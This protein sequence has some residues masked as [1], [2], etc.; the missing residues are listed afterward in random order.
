MAG[1]GFA[2][3]RRRRPAG[4]TPGKSPINCQSRIPNRLAMRIAPRTLLCG[5]AWRIG[6]TV[7]DTGFDELRELTGAAGDKVSLAIGMMGWITALTFNDRITESAVLGDES[8][9]LIESIGD[10]ALTV[11]LIP[12]VLQAKIQAGQTAETHRLS[13]HLIDLAD[14]DA[15]MGNLILGSPLTLG[16][17]VPWRSPKC[18][19]DN[20][21]FADDFRCGP[22]GGA[23]SR[24]DLFATAVLS[25]GLQHHNRRDRARRRHDERRCR[26]AHTGR[27]RR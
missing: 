13:C 24:H 5:N 19:R 11:G 8:V 10:P 2:T 14:G 4:R 3:S 25:Y 18:F 16:L 15:T 6:G 26:R 20:A 9:A 1:P 27:I 17:D 12:L 21:G 22:R 7:A 23:P